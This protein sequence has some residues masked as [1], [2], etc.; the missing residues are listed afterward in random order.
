MTF[1]E[2]LNR[3]SSSGVTVPGNEKVMLNI[4]NPGIAFRTSFLP[5]DGVGLARKADIAKRKQ[6]AEIAMMRAVKKALDPKGVMNPG[7]M[8]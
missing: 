7:K 4:G 5:N 6:P 1:D 2:I 3:F 8:L